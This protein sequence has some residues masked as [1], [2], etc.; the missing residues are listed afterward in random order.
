M[1]Q[2]LTD[3]QAAQI[4][5]AALPKERLYELLYRNGMHLPSITCGTMSG[6]Y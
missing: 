2:E 4:C 6:K 3:K 1:V 5:Q